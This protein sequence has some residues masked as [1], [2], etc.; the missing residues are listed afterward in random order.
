[1]R[2]NGWSVAAG[3]GRRRRRGAGAAVRLQAC[4]ARHNVPLR[5]YVLRRHLPLARVY[6]DRGIFF[7]SLTLL[8]PF[9]SDSD[10]EKADIFKHC[11]KRAK[12][13][14]AVSARELGFDLRREG[15]FF[16]SVEC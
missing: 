16:F 9:F 5:R 8:A 1:M 7:L 3:R 11:N 4:A 6:S 15:I 14:S 10:L 2:I 13:D 12:V